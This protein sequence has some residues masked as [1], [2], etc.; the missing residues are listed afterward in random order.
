MQTGKI[1][2]RIL[3]EPPSPPF[4]EEPYPPDLFRKCVRVLKRFAESRWQLPLG[5]AAVLS[6]GAAIMSAAAELSLMAGGSPRWIEHILNIG[7]ALFLVGVLGGLMVSLWLV[8]MTA[9]WIHR[10]DLWE[11]LCCWTASAA[12]AVIAYL[13]AIWLAFGMPHDAPLW[14]GSD[15]ITQEHERETQNMTR[16]TQ[17]KMRLP[18]C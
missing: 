13:A 7:S 9:V 8:I 2:P 17:T 15:H 16:N 1:S 3:M 14:H 4:D 5:A 10:E 11:A 6:T 18:S 12:A